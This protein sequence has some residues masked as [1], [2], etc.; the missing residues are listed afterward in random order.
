MRMDISELQAKRTELEAQLQTVAASGDT[1]KLE[2]LSREH[3]RIAHHLDLLTEKKLIEQQLTEARSILSNAD[4]ELAAFAREEESRLIQ[5]QTELQQILTDLNQP[6]DPLDERDAIVEIRAGAGGDES[7]LFAAELC[8]MY[9]HYAEAQGWH[10]HLISTNRTGIG[11]YKEVI[12]EINGTDV[13]GKLRYESGVHRVQR[14]PETEKAG[15]VH[16]S[17]ATVAIL[18]I[19]EESDMTIRPEDI[20]LEVSTASG[21]GGQSVNTTYSAVKLTHLP[22]GISVQ[23]QD[24]RSQKQNREKAIEILRARVYAMEQE[25]RRQK[26]SSTRK[27]QIGTGDRSEKIRTY[28]FPQNRLTDH[29]IK[30]NFHNLAAV[31]DG[32]IEEIIAAVQL[33]AKKQS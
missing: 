12:V 19:V 7:G 26:E 30:Q 24:E 6:H 23:C 13:F 25:K 5:R 3:K 20:K 10:T 1:S 14:V 29:R 15:R 11:G 18:P 17:T 22:S 8:R 31:M 32:D 9:T 4:D 27:L 16:T 28:N 21:H 2:K 33:A